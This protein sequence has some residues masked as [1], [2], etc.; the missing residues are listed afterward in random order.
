MGR[1]DT[2]CQ[3]AAGAPRHLTRCQ[4]GEGEARLWVETGLARL[5]RV[6]HCK[7]VLHR[8]G[9][10]VQAR[11]AFTMAAFHVRVQWPG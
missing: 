11:L 2:G 3:A 5:T 1:S 9:A 4:R 6:C 10:Y 8:V 7:Q